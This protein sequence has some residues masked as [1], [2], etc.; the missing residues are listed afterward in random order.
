[1]AKRVGVVLAGC[2]N[3]D[4]TEIR[5]AVLTLLSLE[6]SDALII[7]AAPDVQQTGI[8]DHR[9]GAITAAATGRNVLAESS[10][11]ARGAIRPLSDLSIDDVDALIFPGGRG[12]GTVLSDYA[13]RAELCAVNPDVVRL[14]KGCLGSH[15]PMGFICLAPILAARVLGPAAGVHITL[16]PR[17]TAPFKHATIMGADVRPCPVQEIFIDKKNR[18]VTTPAYMYDDARLPTIAH[19]IEQLVRTVL[20]LAREQRRP[21]QTPAPA[22]APPPKPRSTTAPKPPVPPPAVQAPTVQAPT[23]IVRTPIRGPGSA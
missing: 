7:C 8:V 21:G 19:A 22:P 16:G 18:V 12:V 3:A 14:L 17:G 5:E 11:I 2:G 6:R 1:M 20:L 23:V 10:R 15:R 9:T 13:T 4:G